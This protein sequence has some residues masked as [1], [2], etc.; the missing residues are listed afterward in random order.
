MCWRRRCRV[1]ALPAG[2]AAASFKLLAQTVMCSPFRVQVSSI[3]FVAHCANVPSK[4][5]VVDYR[6]ANGRE[7]SGASFGNTP[8]AAVGAFPESMAYHWPNPTD[9]QYS[10]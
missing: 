9:L 10:I 3:H 7:R 4:K 6:S 5:D 8:I 2:S 1:T